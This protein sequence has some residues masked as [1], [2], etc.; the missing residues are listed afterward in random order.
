MKKNG[1]A[2]E[3]GFLVFL[4]NVKNVNTS[5]CVS[6][7]QFHE[8]TLGDSELLGT[9]NFHR[10]SDFR[11]FSRFGVLGKPLKAVPFGISESDP[12]PVS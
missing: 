3:T 12:F 6:R 4:K 8:L 10:F 5:E 7:F 2:A 9:L 1:A 11:D